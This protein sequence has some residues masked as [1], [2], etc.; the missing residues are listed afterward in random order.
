MHQLISDSWGHK[1]QTES[2]SEP[3]QLSFGQTIKQWGAIRYEAV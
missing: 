2:E 1:Q 3:E